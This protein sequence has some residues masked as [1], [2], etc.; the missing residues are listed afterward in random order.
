MGVM[1]DVDFD[2]GERERL[3]EGGRGELLLMSKHK[4]VQLLF[5]L[6]LFPLLRPYLVWH[7]IMSRGGA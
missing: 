3:G 6:I 1:V 5:L 2:A 7:P 4:W